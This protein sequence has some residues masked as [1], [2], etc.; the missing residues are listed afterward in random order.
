[1]RTHERVPL[2]FYLCAR[3]ITAVF[4]LLRDGISPAAGAAASAAIIFLSAVQAQRDGPLFSRPH[5][6][7]RVWPTALP[8]L[9][10]PGRAFL[11][12]MPGTW[13]VVELRDLPLERARAAADLR[14]KLGEDPVD[15]LLHSSNKVFLKIFPFLV[16]KLNTLSS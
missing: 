9:P 5:C 11:E 7:L 6:A 1:M 16:C 10:E 3:L 8:T 14:G 13:P 2:F 4:Q 15:S 12:E